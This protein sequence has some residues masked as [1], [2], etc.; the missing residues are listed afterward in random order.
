MAILSV[1]GKI[2]GIVINVLISIR[3]FI[4]AIQALIPSLQEPLDVIENLL[5]DSGEMADDFIDRN[6]SAFMKTKELSI[7]LQATGAALEELMDATMGAA[8]D[9]TV[10]LEEVERI[11]SKALAFYA[12]IRDMV[13]MADAASE[14]LSKVKS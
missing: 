6:M 13:S 12:E 4:D 10:T 9:D 5:D 3:P 7:G 8:A 11:K 2:A 14:A 1:I